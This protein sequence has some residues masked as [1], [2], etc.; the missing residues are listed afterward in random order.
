MWSVGREAGWGMQM[1]GGG[2]GGI[3]RDS[4]DSFMIERPTPARIEQ[5]NHTMCNVKMIL[6]DRTRCGESVGGG[7][8]GGG[9]LC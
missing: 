8:G 4:F 6:F 9:R 5:H 7:G 1:G 2:G 3:R